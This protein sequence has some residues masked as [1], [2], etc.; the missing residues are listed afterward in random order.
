MSTVIQSFDNL[1]SDRILR[2]CIGFEAHILHIDTQTEAGEKVR[3]LYRT[4]DS[5]A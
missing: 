3:P 5:L 2:Y 4:A 1:Y